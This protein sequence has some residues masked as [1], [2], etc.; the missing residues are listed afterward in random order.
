MHIHSDQKGGTRL[1]VFIWFVFLFLL[2]HVGLKIVPLY[3]DYA[4][5][6]DEMNMKAGVAQELKDEKI[7][8]DLEIKAKD[9]D[10][11]IQNEKFVIMR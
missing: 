6:E 7:S 1:K 11:V 4:R 2:L 8:R 3:M 9:L 5:M 10:L